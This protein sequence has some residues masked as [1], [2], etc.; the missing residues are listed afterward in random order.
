M[1]KMRIMQPMIAATTPP[2]MGAPPPPELCELWELCEMRA[3]KR[4]LIGAMLEN[5]SCG[6]NNSGTSDN[7]GGEITA[8]SNDLMGSYRCPKQQPTSTYF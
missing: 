6:T 8:A 4:C 1:M 3:F 5:G 7:V 2:P